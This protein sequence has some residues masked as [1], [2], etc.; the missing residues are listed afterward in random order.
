MTNAGDGA[1]ATT[2]R[3]Y[4]SEDATIATTDTQVGTDPVEALAASGSSAESIALTA[5]SAAGTYYYWACVDAVPDESNTTDN[6]SSAVA[7]QVAAAVGRPDLAVTVSRLFNREVDGGTN[8]EVMV[9]NVGTV[10]SANSQLTLYGS[11]DATASPDD[12]RLSRSPEVAP[13]EPGA[14]RCYG[15]GTFLPPQRRDYYYATVGAVPNETSIDN[16]ESAV[17]E[18]PL[19]RC[20][21]CP[22]NCISPN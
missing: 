2:L 5:P 1:A 3:Y 20:S 15:W 21:G 13:L 22:L 6:C 7:V 14:E 19:E 12:F 4:R 10:T 16:N 9:S 11:A 18:S 17:A 8:V